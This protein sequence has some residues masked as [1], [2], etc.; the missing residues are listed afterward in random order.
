VTDSE[1]GGDMTSM[2]GGGVNLSIQGSNQEDV[3]RVTQELMERLKNVKGLINLSSDLTTV[4]PELTIVPDI[5][6]AVAAG[7][8]EQ[9][10]AALQQE[11]YI[12][13]AGSTLPG[14]TVT[15]QG[16]SYPIFIKS[17]TGSLSGVEQARVLKIGFPQTVALGDIA[18]INL[19]DLPSHISHTDTVLS[20]SITASITDKD[21]GAVNNAVQAEIDALSDHPGVEVKTAGVA[22]EMNDTFKKMGLA[23]LIAIG[24][25]FAI[26]ILM[27]R[28]FI[29]PILIM[30]SLPL[31]S[32]GAFLALAVTRVTLSVSALMGMLMLVGIVLTNAIVLVTL[33]DH[34]RKGGLS[35]DEALI[36]GGRT[37]LR[38]IL[39]TALTT[40][41]AMLPMALGMG[42]GAMLTVELAVVVIGGM[43]SSTLLTLLVI[44][45]IYSL[46]Y[47]RKAGAPLKN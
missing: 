36:E 10:I 37:R 30:C 9:Q 40:I 16:E 35:T 28:S 25:V 38:P 45:V 42:S 6:K 27:M 3:A 11:L 5:A 21:V 15:S 43:F 22:E 33:V 19:I 7:M 18:N 34:L 46:V 20:A 29:N 32:I 4:S 47:R 1:S 41:F 31:A 23:I 24:I 39:M 14:Y 2:M 44:P 17:V 8:T 12:L 13:M 26:V